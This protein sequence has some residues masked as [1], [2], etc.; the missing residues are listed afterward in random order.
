MK[1]S[2]AIVIHNE[3][4]ILRQYFE[5]L[6]YYVD[7]FIVADQ[8]STD[9]SIEICK[10]YGARVFKTKHW[11]YSEPDKEFIA[12]QAK[13]DWVIVLDPDERFT[14]EFLENLP[15]I[16]NEADAKKCEGI[17][18]PVKF[19]LD[20]YDME[21]V[22][23][24]V[25][26][27]II[28]KGVKCSTRI[29]S[30]YLPQQVLT[31]N[32]PQYH[33][34]SS[35]EHF[36]EEDERTQLNIPERIK[37]NSIEQNLKLKKEL[38]EKREKTKEFNKNFKSDVSNFPPQIIIETSINCNANCIMCPNDKLE[39]KNRNMPMALF[40]NL[41]DQCI[42][43]GV[44]QI[45]P[46]MHGEPFMVEDI[47]EK[48]EYVNEKLP[49]TQITIFT[50]GNLLDDEKAKKLLKIRNVKIFFSID[51]YTKETY[52]KIRKGLDFE[53]TKANILN[54]IKLNNESETPI[55]TGVSMTRSN[56][57]AHEISPFINFW[58]GKVDNIDTHRC[59]GRNIDV[60]AYTSE[61]AAAHFKSIACGVLF[62]FM[63]INTDG[64]VSMCCEDYTPKVI[65]G[66][67]NNESIE[68]IWN[69]KRF[70]A[71]RKAHMEGRKSDLMVCK[72]CNICM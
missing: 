17:Q 66:N 69:G 52:E 28:K 4:P 41:I 59:T 43:K 72:T 70:N 62:N 55:I 16:L 13:N 33:F 15:K 36:G 22:R 53:K 9:N 25:Q 29:H 47:F 68:T 57:N 50:N 46:F 11:G 51:A 6:K 45:H 61:E 19:I 32:I 37:A 5:H 12:K 38:K 2:A 24:R 58:N 49:A 27:R 64:N 71:I 7:D 23:G 14:T 18:C 48:L 8:N 1:I 3:G 63:C 40:K 67:V 54:F 20:G 60:P 21:L 34:K 44:E 31:V 30:A 56:Y 42:G 26:P 39:R 35:K 65:L 10:E